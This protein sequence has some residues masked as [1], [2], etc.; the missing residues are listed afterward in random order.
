MKEAARHFE[1]F[2]LNLQ[3]QAVGAYAPA[4][5]SR[6]LLGWRPGR[7]VR[8]GSY[9]LDDDD[10][11]AVDYFDRMFEYLET[12]KVGWK[13]SFGAGYTAVRSGG[14]YYN[15]RHERT[16]FPSAGLMGVCE[17]TEKGEILGLGDDGPHRRSDWYKPV[18]TDS[19][20][21]AFFRG[22][23][24]SQ[25]SLL[26]GRTPKPFLTRIL[27]RLRAKERASQAEVL[28]RTGI[29]G[30]S[31]LSR[32]P[33][34]ADR[35]HIDVGAQT[36]SISL[37]EAPVVANRSRQRFPVPFP[38]GYMLSVQPNGEVSR[39]QLYVTAKFHTKGGS[40]VRD[41]RY[42]SQMRPQGF[43]YHAKYGYWTPVP[44]DA[45]DSLSFFAVKA[46]DGASL[47]SVGLVSPSVP[48]EVAKFEA[49]PLLSENPA[50]G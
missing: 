2:H 12:A 34:L 30:D 41:D 21:P 18:I 29:L 24:R 44:E 47:A 17:L 22:R 36:E 13:V 20:A 3:D 31:G 26:S 8:F 38:E 42:E 4:A 50:R 16:R 45:W 46:P 48:T 40:V 6:E 14:A 32:F 49:S 1:F 43:Q 19:T 28:N 33:T 10:L 5:V 35:I 25:D 39:N 23:N 11:L 37:I 9:R 7:R 27:I 15:V